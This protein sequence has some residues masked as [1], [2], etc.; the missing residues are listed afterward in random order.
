MR[1]IRVAAIV[2][3]GMVIR[4]CPTQDGAHSTEVTSSTSG[5]VTS[6]ESPVTTSTTITTTTTTLPVDVNGPDAGQRLDE[7]GWSLCLESGSS[8]PKSDSYDDR[9]EGGY[10][11]TGGRA[12]GS[13]A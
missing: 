3:L 8:R 7:T 11:T 10:P 4:P 5:A 12:G 2:L 13:V 9:D 6:T 1:R